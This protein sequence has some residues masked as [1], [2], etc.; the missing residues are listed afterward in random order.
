MNYL[1]SSTAAEEAPLVALPELRMFDEPD[2][3]SNV[4]LVVEDAELHVHKE[5]DQSVQ[6]YELAQKIF[7][8]VGPKSTSGLLR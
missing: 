3:L 5:V 7:Y 2:P 4:I 6:S 1:E 8:F